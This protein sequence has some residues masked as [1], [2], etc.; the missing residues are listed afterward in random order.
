VLFRNK[1][2][3]NLEVLMMLSTKL[4][5]ANRLT[6]LTFTALFLAT[7]ISC[8]K[9]PTTPKNL[10]K[11]DSVIMISRVT[12]TP[13]PEFWPRP[14]PS[15]D[16]VLFFSQNQEALNSQSFQIKLYE[17]FEEDQAP[18]TIPFASH[19]CWSPG[20]EKFI[21]VSWKEE[22]P[23]FASTPINSLARIYINS[24]PIGGFDTQPEIS[25]DGKQIAF[26]SKFLSGYHICTSNYNGSNFSIFFRGHSPQWH[27]DSSLIVFDKLS[28]SHLHI[29]DLHPASSTITQ[30]TSGKHNN[31]FPSYSPDGNWIT[32]ISDR[33]ADDCLHLYLM[34]ADGSDVVQLTDGETSELHPKWAPDGFIYFISTG[35]LNINEIK[36]FSNFKTSDIYRLKPSVR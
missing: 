21:Y 3:I 17:M 10:S 11:T 33:S 15:G 6:V 29:F 25:P 7:L 8:K 34:R 16:K 35:K 24:G 18:Y 30:L 23:R 9:K 22:K 12:D 2:K 36:N 13:E 4:S 32:F 27:P 28:D 1:L 19:P 20:G 26:Q 31:I 14:S 5:F